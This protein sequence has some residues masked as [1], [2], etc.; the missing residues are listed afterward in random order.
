[1]CKRGEGRLT[2]W[3]VAWKVDFNLSIASFEQ[4][5]QG[6]RNFVD[7]AI[8]SPY[9]KAPTVMFVS[10]VGIFA[11]TLRLL[12]SGRL[13]ST[14]ARHQCTIPGCKI[15]PPVPEIPIDDPASPFG[16]G[17]SE[18]KWVS[19]RVLQNVTEQRGLH[20]VVMRLGHVAGDRMGYWNEREW[21]PALVKSALFTRCL[22][23]V[24]GVRR[25]WPVSILM[26]TT[27]RDP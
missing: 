8:S 4:D 3:L 16:S 18:S 25:I 17:Y 21:F 15:A 19:E 11:G 9:K 7:L 14:Y 26:Q 12:C 1:M 10:S 27:D 13:S 24:D 2:D 6:A 23:D 22:P 20:T 5:I